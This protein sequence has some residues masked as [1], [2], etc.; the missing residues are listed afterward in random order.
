MTTAE[1][2]ELESKVV[3][4]TYSRYPVSFERGRGTRLWDK[5][6]REYLD[7]FSGLAVMAVG[8]P[9]PK[10]VTAVK[11]QASKLM[12]DTNYYYLES[13]ILLAKRLHD[14]SFQ[15]RVFFVN[16]G[17]EASELAIKLARK[18]A[19]KNLSPN[20]YEII[21]MTNSF[22]GR[23]LAA[24]TATGQLKYHKGMEPMVLGFNY[25]AFNDLAAVEK[26]V[27]TR[28]CA[29]LVEPIQGEGGIKVGE[30]AFLKGLRELCDK[31][32][33]T[34]IFDEVQT[35]LGRT[36][37]MFAYEHY[38]VTPD[39]MTLAKA[40]GGGLP[41]GAVVARPQVAEAFGKGDHGTTLGGNPVASAA[42]L[43]T[44]DVIQ[45]ENLVAHAE[46][47]GK[48]L[49]AKLEELRKRIPKIVEVRG[50]GLLVGVEVEAETRA[51][52]S[53]CLRM[54][55]VLNATADKVIRFLPPLT[56]NEAEVDQAVDTLE[57]AFLAVG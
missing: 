52:V 32:K 2:I 48:Y 24:L 23:T 39:I 6:G 11:E 30:P 4:Q 38:G 46:S 34:L 17:T 18:Y 56:A 44:L 21:T 20:H 57:K 13:Q 33:L 47:L 16:S 1:L 55:V 25:A 26:Y 9:H 37:K 35:G 7:F 15:G 28:T 29:V 54:G 8:H 5:D 10:V 36:G 53:E 14:L 31:H 3:A 50:K 51:L 41:L 19:K 45:E 49:L 12:H 42:G 27:N 40:L 43:A 22:H